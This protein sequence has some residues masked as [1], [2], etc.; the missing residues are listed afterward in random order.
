[1]EVQLPAQGHIFGIWW[2]QD[3][4][5]DFSNPSVHIHIEGL[6]PRGQGKRKMGLWSQGRTQECHRGN[7]GSRGAGV[8][9]GK[10]G[11]FQAGR[12]A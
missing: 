12:K 10:V 2:N 9:G 5:L 7:E 3:S 11:P 8:W 1:M 6:L 4:N